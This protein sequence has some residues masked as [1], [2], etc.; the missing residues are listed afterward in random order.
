MLD[1]VRTRLTLWYV[2]ALAL[3][4]I[5]FAALIF[6]LT[7]R[8]LNRDLNSR[9]EEMARNFKFSFDAEQAEEIDKKTP[10]DEIIRVTLNEFKFRDYQFAVFAA[11][12][13][14]IDSTADFS[15]PP[16]PENLSTFSDV[17]AA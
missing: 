9:L 7:D 5:V 3:V 16:Q 15:L 11:D 2:G 13:R 10:P 6:I 8:V 17:E 1:S 4:I 14:L 12:G